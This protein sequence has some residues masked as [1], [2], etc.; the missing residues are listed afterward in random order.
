MPGRSENG[1]K[2]RWNSAKR[3]RGGED[4]RKGNSGKSKAIRK[5]TSWPGK[6]NGGKDSVSMAGN[7][8]KATSSSSSSSSSSHTNVQKK[9]K[10]DI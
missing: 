4:K 1:I 2:N 5:A 3:R 8:R 7:K 6:S 9:T 10:V